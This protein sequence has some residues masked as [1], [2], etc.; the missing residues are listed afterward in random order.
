MRG[1]VWHT[2][3]DSDTEV[4]EMFLRHAYIYIIPLSGTAVE[5]PVFIREYVNTS[6]FEMQ[7]LARYRLNIRAKH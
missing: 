6:S 4:T 3:T 7:G 5:E 2:D 1:L